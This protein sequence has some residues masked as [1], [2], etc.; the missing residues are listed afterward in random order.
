VTKPLDRAI[1][2]CKGV[3][4]LADAIGVGQ[5][6]VSNWKARNTP[7]D[8]AFCARIERATGATVTCEQLRPDV[9]WVRVKDKEWPNK[10]GRPLV[11]VSD[12]AGA[13]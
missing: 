11:D 6:V 8:P 3:G 5:S 12:K 1:D 4:K 10:S 7:I 2:A 13:R 9:N